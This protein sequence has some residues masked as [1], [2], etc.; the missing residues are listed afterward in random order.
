MFLVS[1]NKNLDKP[2]T[3]SCVTFSDDTTENEP[4]V[5]DYAVRQKIY[6]QANT[7]YGNIRRSQYKEI[8]T[9][10]TCSLHIDFKRLLGMPFEPD[11]IKKFEGAVPFKICKFDNKLM[12]EISHCNNKV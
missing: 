1:D 12:I 3:P 10:L 4:I 5:G 11:N 6:N 7:I 2:L 9:L 8:V